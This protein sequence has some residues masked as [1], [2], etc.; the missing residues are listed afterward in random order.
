M[1]FDYVTTLA[2]DIEQW[3][4]ATDKSAHLADWRRAMHPAAA[5]LQRRLIPT[6]PDTAAATLPPDSALLSV[7][8]RLAKP[9]LSKDNADFDILDNPVRKEWVFK[10]PEVASTGW[11][12]AFRAALDRLGQSRTAPVVVRLVGPPRPSDNNADEELSA[13]ALTFFPTFFDPNDVAL[14]MINPHDRLT[15]KGKNPIHFECVREGAQGTLTI[16]YVPAPGASPAERGEDM[17][18]LAEGV[19]AMLTIYGFGAKTSSG[20]GVARIAHGILTINA[21]LIATP[22]AA[23]AGGAMTENLPRYLSAPGVLIEDLRAADGSLITENEFKARIE[24][25]GKAYKRA[26]AQ[27]YQKAM[28]WWETEA[29]VTEMPPPMDEPVLSIP[30][31]PFT[32]ADELRRAAADIVD[33][34][35]GGGNQ[36]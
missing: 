34:L 3:Y 24:G 14:E 13:G 2:Q 7:T 36:S 15:G 10:T 20:F 18:L 29:N 33:Q 27:L 4:G 22:P 16:V 31:W 23:E 28:K 6:P 25:N 12:G 21:R 19:V 5:A 9:Y 17:Q 8:F 1:S 30:T 11:K 35:S 32:N 26:D